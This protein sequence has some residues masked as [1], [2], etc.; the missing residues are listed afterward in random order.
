M[1]PNV[2]RGEAIEEICKEIPSMITREQNLALMQETTLE[3]VEEIVKD[4]KKI[5]PQGLTVSQQNSIK[6][7]GTSLDKIS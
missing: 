2:D 3:E 6:L 7:D 1:E 4:M 5:K